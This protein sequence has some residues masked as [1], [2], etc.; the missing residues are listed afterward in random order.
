MTFRPVTGQI[1]QS[2]TRLARAKGERI[3]DPA[4]SRVRWILHLYPMLA[5][6]GSIG[7][8]EALR[9]NAFE[10]HIAGHAE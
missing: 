9:D 5:L 2:E 7:A 10:T 3:P 4:V 8:I 1:F 6:S